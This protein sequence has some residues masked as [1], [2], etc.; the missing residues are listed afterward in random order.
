MSQFPPAMPRALANQAK[1]M[2]SRSPA[3]RAADGQASE[4]GTLGSWRMAH[5]EDPEPAAPPES[6]DFWNQELD[7]GRGSQAE[8]PHA[9]QPAQAAPVT[10]A[11][12]NFVDRSNETP[13]ARRLREQQDKAAKSGRRSVRYNQMGAHNAI[14]VRLPEHLQ[15]VGS[16]ENERSVLV[17]DSR[18]N[19]LQSPYQGW[20]L[21]EILI[22]ANARINIMSDRALVRSPSTGYHMNLFAQDP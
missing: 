1:M 7:Q 4:A 19:R 10:Q 5:D 6:A 13:A 2:Q 22:N 20:L 18:D 16:G 17:L 9:P 15:Q 11:A 8:Q 3:A 12:R 14:N 21:D